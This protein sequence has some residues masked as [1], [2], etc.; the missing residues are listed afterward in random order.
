MVTQCGLRAVSAREARP[1]V[2]DSPESVAESALNSVSEPVS[3]VNTEARSPTTQPPSSF[4]WSETPEPTHSGGF[5][6]G[7]QGLF[8]RGL[9]NLFGQKRI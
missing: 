7:L 6:A 3:E 2:Q 5:L 8:G 1:E 4:A 9:Q